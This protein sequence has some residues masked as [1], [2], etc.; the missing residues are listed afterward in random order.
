MLNEWREEGR[1]TKTIEKI[2]LETEADEVHR[3]IG[4]W[5]KEG[6][7]EKGKK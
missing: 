6:R 7:E 4:W 3:N 5:E 2:I 1:D